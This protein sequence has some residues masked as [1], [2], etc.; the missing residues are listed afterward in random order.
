MPK[1]KEGVL[2]QLASRETPKILAFSSL[3]LQ[4]PLDLLIL[5]AAADLAGWMPLMQDLL[6]LGS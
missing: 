3:F 2:S 1:A 6:L 4:F 5:C